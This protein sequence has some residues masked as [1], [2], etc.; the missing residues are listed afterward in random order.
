[1]EKRSIEDRN[2]RISETLT[3]KEITI[4]DHQTLYDLMCRIYPPAYINYWEDNGEWY[5]NDLYNSKNLQKELEETNADYYFVVLEDKIIGILRIVWNLDT[6]YQEDK[7]YVKLHR[8]YLD[9]TIQNKGIGYQLMIW[10]I[11][12]ATKKG[13]KKLWLEVME[14]QDQA[15]YFYQKL[16]FK[17]VDKVFIE[18]PLVYEEYRGMYKMVKTLN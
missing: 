9:Q 4:E 8:L 15:L 16:D 10:L 3:L 13:Y 5:V 11:N 14:K 7:N 6:H 12:S 1:M 2:L 17:E 18:F